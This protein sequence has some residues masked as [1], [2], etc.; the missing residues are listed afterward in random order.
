MVR[1]LAVT[2]IAALFA[3][4]IESMAFAA[5]VVGTVSDAQGNPVAGVQ[6]TAQVPGGKVI[7]QASAG[8]DGKYQLDGLAPETYA[9]ALN[10]L[11]SG[12]K[13]GTAVA[14]LGP[15]GLT[16]DWKLSP[17]APAMALA[18][19]GTQV[20]VAG[21]PFGYS[22]SEFAS[23]VTLAA[24]GVAGGVVG[25]YGAAGGFSSGGSA[26]SPAL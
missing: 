18:S 10:P 12:F 22:A 13:G 5:E 11:Q 17:K 15:K 25:G 20:A 6:I 23:L 7:A 2:T 3:I 19:E 4:A 1:K 14:A 21:D 9:Y 8:A 26:A 16:I 24:G